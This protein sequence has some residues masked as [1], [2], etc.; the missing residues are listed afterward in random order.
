M[1]LVLSCMVMCVVFML[2]DLVIMLVGVSM[3]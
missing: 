1:S 2:F 3:L